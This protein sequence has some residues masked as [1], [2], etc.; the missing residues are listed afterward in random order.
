MAASKIWMEAVSSKNIWLSTGKNVRGGHL[1][2]EREGKGVWIHFFILPGWEQFEINKYGVWFQAGSWQPFCFEGGRSFSHPPLFAARVRKTAQQRNW[3]CVLKKEKILLYLWKMLSTFDASSNI[4]LSCSNAHTCI[5]PGTCSHSSSV[6]GS[7]SMVIPWG[8]GG[9][10]DATKVGGDDQ[11]IYFKEDS[12]FA[13]TSTVYRLRQ[14]SSS[15]QLLSDSN[16][17]DHLHWFKKMH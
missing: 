9:T 5:S 16:S 8:W 12:G 17:H 11:F 15:W 2:V 4:M 7:I 13:P 6:P 3:K 10:G 14:Q 1:V